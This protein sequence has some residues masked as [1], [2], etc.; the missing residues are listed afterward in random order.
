MSFTKNSGLSGELPFSASVGK[1]SFSLKAHGDLQ[2]GATLLR[3]C[4]VIVTPQGISLQQQFRQAQGMIQN[5]FRL[6][7]SS[8]DWLGGSAYSE[9]ISCELFGDRKIDGQLRFSQPDHEAAVVCESGMELHDFSVGSGFT[10]SVNEISFQWISQLMWRLRA[11]LLIRLSE[12]ARHTEQSML[13]PGKQLDHPLKKLA[14]PIVAASAT[15]SGYLS[16]KRNFS[17]S[18]GGY[19]A[20][21]TTTG[22]LNRDF[23]KLQ[24]VQT[25]RAETIPANILSRDFAAVANRLLYLKDAIRAIA[26][27]QARKV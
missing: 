24:P 4:E 20:S 18:S 25:E 6:D 12:E 26:K 13:S 8:M 5:D 27:I 2:M 7:N 3:D 16:S 17:P 10:E 19:L 11:L 21:R 22:Y 9:I 15:T 1:E 23:K 14:E